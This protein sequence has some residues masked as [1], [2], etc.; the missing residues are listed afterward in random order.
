MGNNGNGNQT[1]QSRRGGKREGAG[2]PRGRVAIASLEEKLAIEDRARA[3]ASIAL[4]ALRDIASSGESES[5]RVAAAGQLLDRGY[6]RARQAID[7]SG[8]ISNL[9][10]VSI[11]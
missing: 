11:E 2:R 4:K 5:A 10:A 3:F 7:H 1:N 8:N 6:G 9:P